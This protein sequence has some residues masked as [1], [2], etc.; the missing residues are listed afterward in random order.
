MGSGLFKPYP[1]DYNLRVEH[2]YTPNNFW[3]THD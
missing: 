3:S 2:L 1:H